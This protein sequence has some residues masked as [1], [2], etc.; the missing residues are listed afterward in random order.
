MWLSATVSILTPSQEE[1]GF[2]SKMLDQASALHCTKSVLCYLRSLVSPT[3]SHTLHVALFTT[4]SSS[5]MTFC[6]QNSVQ[7]TQTQGIDFSFLLLTS[8][9]C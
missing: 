5:A 4:G 7:G 1:L 3:L 8:V 9:F 6:T 2:H